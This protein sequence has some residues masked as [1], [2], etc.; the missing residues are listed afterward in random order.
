MK[1]IILEVDEKYAD[2]LSITLI[3]SYRNGYTQYGV[4]VA[5]RAL[6]IRSVNH[7]VCDDEGKLKEDYI[8]EL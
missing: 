8:E 1:K 2:V 5:S 7:I 6:D 4:N 3:G